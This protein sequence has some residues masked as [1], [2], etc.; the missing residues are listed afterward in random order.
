VQPGIAPSFENPD[1]L[2]GVHVR[3]DVTFWDGSPLTIDDVL[4]R[5]PA[6]AGLD[7]RCGY[8]FLT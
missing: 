1:P 8:N 5:G 7:L 6:V 2:T 3:D 4:F